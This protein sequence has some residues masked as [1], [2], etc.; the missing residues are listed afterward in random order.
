MEIPMLS[1]MPM[2]ATLPR[3]TSASLEENISEPKPMTFEA[4]GDV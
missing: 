1:R 2:T 3:L 4:A